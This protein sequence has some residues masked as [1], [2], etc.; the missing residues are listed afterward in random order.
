VVKSP[1]ASSSDRVASARKSPRNSRNFFSGRR[2]DPR[3]LRARAASG[4]RSQKQEIE[5]ISEIGA[6]LSMLGFAK[7]ATT[8]GCTGGGGRYR[9]RRPERG[10]QGRRYS[11]HTLRRGHLIPWGAS[12][13]SILS[14][15][16]RYCTNSGRRADLVL[17]PLS[18]MCGRLRVGKSFLHVG[19]IGRCSRVF[20]LYMRFT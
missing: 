20:G 11:S 15:D 19:S 3:S 14:S 5:L 10:A 7:Q 1:E 4:V 9:G 6:D 17:G 13:K 2:Q 8:R 18:A 16:V 12:S